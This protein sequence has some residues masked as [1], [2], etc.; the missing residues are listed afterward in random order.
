MDKLEKGK[1]IDAERK[2]GFNGTETKYCREENKEK[3]PPQMFDRTAG[4]KFG[5]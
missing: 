1:K 2:R 3:M 5:R 4:R